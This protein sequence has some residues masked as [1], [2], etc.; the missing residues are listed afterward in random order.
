[1]MRGEPYTKSIP[2]TQHIASRP[3]AVTFAAARLEEN[4]EDQMEE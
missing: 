4:K 3:Y 2:D 1:M